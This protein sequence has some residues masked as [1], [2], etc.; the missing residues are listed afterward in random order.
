MNI[1]LLTSDY[2]QK[3]PHAIHPKCLEEN[4]RRLAEYQI[5][6]SRVQVLSFKD[7]NK[8]LASLQQKAIL[9]I[10][11]GH[12]GF[13]SAALNQEL[14]EKINSLVGAGRINVWGQC[15]GANMLC[16]NLYVHCDDEWSLFG[17]YLNLLNTTAYSQTYP[18]E[19]YKVAN[20]R[21]A[22][23]EQCKCFW[24]S[25]SHFS[26]TNYYSERNNVLARY[27]NN[28]PAIIYDKNLRGSVVI[29]SGIHPELTEILDD[30]TNSQILKE[31]LGRKNLLESIYRMLGVLT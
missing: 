16:K 29:A 15:S 2:S 19:G 7:L 12:T 14:Q 20:I 11:G 18:N 28:Q 1:Y 24:F 13:L 26:E 23:E 22:S 30:P 31:D 27:D 4:Q 17:S 3:P 8:A 10:P 5:D 25:G 9:I 6:P 21:T